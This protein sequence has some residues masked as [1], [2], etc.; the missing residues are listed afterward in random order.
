MSD[1]AVWAEEFATDPE[2][3]GYANMTDAERVAAANAV[4][5]PGPVSGP[6]L[7]MWLAGEV[8]EKIALGVEQGAT[9]TLRG[10]CRSALLMATG[11]D[12]YV[13]SDH[14]PMLDALVA[15]AIITQSEADALDSK[16]SNQQSRAS[17][18]G[19]RLK[20]GIAERARTI[21]GG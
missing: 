15:G 18:L 1:E 21:N 19:G 4:T 7:R 9:A 12:S 6:S 10:L 16:A 2:G 8:H 5:R 3:I 14:K 20:V 17:E 11:E 13:R